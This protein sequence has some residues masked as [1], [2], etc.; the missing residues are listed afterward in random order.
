MVLTSEGT[1][2]LQTSLS[3]APWPTGNLAIPGTASVFHLSSSHTSS[4]FPCPQA[5]RAPLLPWWPVISPALSLHH[6]W[7]DPW[8]PCFPVCPLKWRMCFQSSVPQCQCWDLG[9][10]APRVLPLNTPFLLNLL[11]V[12]TVYPPTLT[13]LVTDIFSLFLHV[14]CLHPIIL[15]S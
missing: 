9:L 1:R 3:G 4:Y 11:E 7:T 5:L 10:V 6:T 12:H 15:S 14:F 13:P 2:W 8:G